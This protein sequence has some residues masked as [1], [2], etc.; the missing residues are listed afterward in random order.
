MGIVSVS[1]SQNCFIGIC[2]FEATKSGLIHYGKHVQMYQYAEADLNEHVRVRTLGYSFM[3][4]FSNF[5]R[6]RNDV[7][8]LNLSKTNYKIDI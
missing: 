3:K 7:G 2:Y 8:N 5:M 4:H 1:N 6:L